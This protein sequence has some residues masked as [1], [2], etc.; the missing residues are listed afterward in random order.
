MRRISVATSWAGTVVETNCESAR[1]SSDIEWKTPRLE[2]QNTSRPRGRTRRHGESTD[3]APPNLIG[4]ERQPG[5]DTP[6]DHVAPVGIGR[7][8]NVC[9][10]GL[11]S[12]AGVRMIDANDLERRGER[13]ERTAQ[14][15][16]LARGDAVAC[17]ALRDVHAR[18]RK[19]DLAPAA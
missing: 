2:I 14:V 15:D 9:R 13:A 12:R 3:T 7:L 18:H 8:C 5:P 11:G 4:A 1:R 17:L 10:R 16:V 19:G 6:D